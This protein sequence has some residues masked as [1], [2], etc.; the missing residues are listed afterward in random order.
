MVTWQR[1]CTLRSCAWKEERRVR[2]KMLAM[3]HEVVNSTWVVIHNDMPA[4]QS[5]ATIADVK[6]LPAKVS[7]T[8]SGVSMM[9]AT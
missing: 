1:N 4:A 7:D 3:A 6:R 9:V 2:L 8:V 5:V